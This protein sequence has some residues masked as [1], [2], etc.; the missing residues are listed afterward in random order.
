M[1]KTGCADG[2]TWETRGGRRCERRNDQPSSFEW[3][4]NAKGHI[5]T[6]EE[7]LWQDQSVVPQPDREPA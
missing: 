4:R 5:M 7:L 2:A 1:I 3:P 6:I